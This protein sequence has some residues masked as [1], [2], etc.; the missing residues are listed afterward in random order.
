[1]GNFLFISLM[2]HRALV[3]S[4]SYLPRPMAPHR[5]PEPTRLCTLPCVCELVNSSHLF[6]RI[7]AED[8]TSIP[9]E[10]VSEGTF[11]SHCTA[12]S[13]YSRELIIRS[14]L[15]IH[16]QAQNCAITNFICPIFPPC[17]RPQRQ[18]ATPVTTQR[19]TSGLSSVRTWPVLLPTK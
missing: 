1:M 6:P 4:R 19:N 2:A 18:I 14:S 5:S 12:P 13:P 11:T 10:I 15:A 17:F 9:S 8:F 16:C 3:T 7:R